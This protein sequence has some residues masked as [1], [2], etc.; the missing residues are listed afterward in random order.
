MI[1]VF[2]S[3]RIL[4][5]CCAISLLFACSQEPQTETKSP[6]SAVSTAADKLADDVIARVG[7][8]AIRF[9][10]LNTMLN[11][12]A[13]VG[14][15]IPALGTPERDAVRITLL[16]KVVSAN[17]VYLD[18]LRKGVD[19][20]PAYQR[21]M[22]RFSTAMLADTYVRSY[23]KR[24]TGI[25]EADLQA[26]IDEV[27]KP[28]TEITDEL[29]TVLKTSLQKRKTE[30]QRAVLREQLRS[31][32]DIKVFATNIYPEGDD[33]REDDI[34]VASY[35]GQTITW[36]DVRERMIAAGKGAV[37]RDPVAM[38]SDAR[39]QYLQ[40]EIDTRLLA[41]KARDEGLEQ[42]DA[43]R[44]RYNEYAKTRLINLHRANLAGDMQPSDDELEAYFEANRDSIVEPEY[45]KVQMV[46]LNTEEEANSVKKRVEAGEITMFQAASSHSVAPDARQNLGE[47]GWVAR[48]KLKRELDALVF[49][50]GP[51]EIG[52]P[53]EAGGLWHIVTVQ[54]VRDAQN[55]DLEEAETR[56]LARR[57]YIRDKLND[58]VVNLRKNEFEVEV[59]EDVILRLAQQEVDMVRQMTEKAQA[60][61]SVTQQRLEEM[62]KLMN[63]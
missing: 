24:N 20:D 47:I 41:Q 14:L 5:Q 62:Q 29:R 10:E 18:A 51:A 43:Y 16:D 27:V 9:S 7:E 26:Y 15:S 25:S 61:G 11:S 3:I 45:R 28:G 60:P 8:Q 36:G 35:G 34:P 55:A 4:I 31:G 48:G 63:P 37:A 22:Q 59:Y 23:M 49:K 39:L 46:M 2:R 19:K 1:T 53:V 21:A 33:E 38:E 52:G 13:V 42:D 30:E 32:G 44:A 58:Y 40:N 57:S 17:L 50:L 6:D 54:D 12:S 56:R